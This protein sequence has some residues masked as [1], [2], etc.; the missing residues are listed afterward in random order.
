MESKLKKSIMEM[1]D[2]IHDIDK[3]ER[4]HRFIQYI[5]CGK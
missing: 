4:I 5:L 1:L 3:L 2:M